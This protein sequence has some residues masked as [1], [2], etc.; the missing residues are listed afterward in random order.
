M[1]SLEFV[2]ATHT[3]LFSKGVGN[4][5]GGGI[6]EW[7]RWSSK[8]VVNGQLQTPKKTTSRRVNNK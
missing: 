6:P 2:G 1:L 8:R 7:Q 4:G 5:R 3:P